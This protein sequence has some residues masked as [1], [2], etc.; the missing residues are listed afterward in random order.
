MLMSSGQKCT[1]PEHQVRTVGG[2]NVGR[3]LLHQ[4]WLETRF[5]FL[6]NFYLKTWGVWC[7]LNKMY[8]VPSTCWEIHPKCKI[9]KCW[10]FVGLNW[11]ILYRKKERMQRLWRYRRMFRV[12][13][14]WNRVKYMRI[15]TVYKIFPHIVITE[16]AM[17]NG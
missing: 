13:G 9:F 6:Y 11:R 16:H 1:K 17:Q 4:T 12:N 8:N 14:K 10:Q 2:R 3:A 15:T 5:M 7:F